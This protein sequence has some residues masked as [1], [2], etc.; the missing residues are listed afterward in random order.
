MVAEDAGEQVVLI[1]ISGDAGSHLSVLKLKS[2]NLVAQALS[3]YSDPAALPLLVHEV[4][5]LDWP[6]IYFVHTFK[7]ATVGFGTPPG[8]V[9]PTVSTDVQVESL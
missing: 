8:W 2:T 9:G 7:G 5:F 3:E 4:N 6:L 1:H